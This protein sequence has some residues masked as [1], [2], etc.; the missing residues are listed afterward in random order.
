MSHIVTIQTRVSDPKAVE[1]ACQRLGLP[2][3]TEGT[4]KLFGSE[5]SGL[6]VQLPDWHYPVVID[7]GTG[8]VS[9]DNYQGH[10]GAQE[11]LDRFLQCYAVEKA[12]LEA[13]KRGYGVVEQA[14]SDGSIML[15]IVEGS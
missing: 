1:A 3:P 11:H 15:R 12:R 5:V 10:W 14:L 13:W 4:A 7:T 6:L 8:T 2:A 9:Y